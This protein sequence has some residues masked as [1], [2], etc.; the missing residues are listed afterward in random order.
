MEINGKNN[1]R[2]QCAGSLFFWLRRNTTFGK[3]D[4]SIERFQS[5]NY[6]SKNNEGLALN[7]IK[8]AIQGSFRQNEQ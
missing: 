8:A 2:F 7:R 5:K 3:N 6:C 1:Y 4:C